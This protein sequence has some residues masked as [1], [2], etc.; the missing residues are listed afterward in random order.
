[1][2]RARVLWTLPAVA[3]LLGVG[4]SAQDE[5]DDESPRSTSV[6]ERT[7]ARL[8]Q[9]DVTLRGPAK[10]LD[11][12]TRDDFTLKVGLI[13]IDDF[14]VDKV[15]RDPSAGRSLE[16]PAGEIR[17]PEEPTAVPP[18][19]LGPTT[20]LFYFDQPHLTMAGRQESIE[21]ARAMIPALIVDG[22]RASI[23]SNARSVE[24]LVEMSDD[25]DELLVAIKKLEGDP[26]QWDMYAQQEET[27]IERVL[28]Y[29]GIVGD[30]DT[31][32]SQSDYRRAL[33]LAK[34]FYQEELWRAERDLRRFA[35]VLARFAPVDQPKAVIY[36]ADNMRSNAGEHYLDLF[37]E[38]AKREA[39]ESV[40]QGQDQLDPGG[41]LMKAQLP[42][43][44]VVNQ[45]SAY[46]IRL[47]PIEAQGLVTSTGAAPTTIRFR[48]AEN[49]LSDLATETGGEAFLY[50]VRAPKIIERIEEDLACLYLV[51]FD[52]T[53][54]PEDNPLSVRL[55]VKR[56]KVKVQ[57][58]GRITLES[59]SS[60][61]TSRLLAAFA[62]PEAVESSIA[63]RPEVIPTGHTEKG[64][65]AIVQVRVPGSE[66]PGS[67]WDLGASVLSRGKVREAA[68]RLTVGRAG[69]PVVLQQPMV[70]R[71]GPYEIVAVAHNT[72]VDTMGSQQIEGE[73][74][75]PNENLAAVGP[76]AVLQPAPAA[77]QLGEAIKTSGLL[78]FAEE[79]PVRVDRPVALVTVICRSQDV[80]GVLDVERQLV[81]ASSVRFD[82]MEMDLD[83]DSC[84]LIRD[85]VP[86]D[87]MTPG[88]FRYR[89]Q[90]HD[91]PDELA[92][93]ERR[94]FAWDGEPLA[95]SAGEATPAGESP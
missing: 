69:A 40:E 55:N 21:I 60:R 42:F 4:V 49:T 34:Q 22:N 39:S 71:P 56:P 47:Y 2:N 35:M 48:H 80:K 62:S 51:S 10:S 81:G 9:L 57:V 33:T 32:G 46:G 64:F 45:A 72:T 86:K 74:P 14:E 95:S 77:I 88:S 12:L 26:E 6:V 1:M 3:L 63:V 58:R 29:L 17:E 85:V 78:A 43:D 65:N 8:V 52:P 93:A 36:M 59:E 7:G 66:I 30:E 79:V 91:G 37:G 82:P 61:L 25:P 90:I 75:K 70:F 38:F 94:F 24:T 16:V 53:G 67:T 19:G 87:T 92:Q 13:R 73:W 76:I 15:C 28:E 31:I 84:A 50:G 54:L 11:A 41:V 44:Q 68:G 18:A 83:E 23:V 89:I 20:F 5:A 27:R